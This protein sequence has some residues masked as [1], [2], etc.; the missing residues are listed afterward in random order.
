MRSPPHGTVISE[1]EVTDISSR[2]IWVVAH[3]EKLFLSYEHFPW[4]KRATV[5]TISNV[6]EPSP[7]HFHWPDLDIDLGIET[8]RDPERFPLMFDTSA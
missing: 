8:M 5:E 2:G 3:G 7:G 4:F 6:E 1:I